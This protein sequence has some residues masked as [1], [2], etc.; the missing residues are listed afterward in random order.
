MQ[1]VRYPTM[2]SKPWLAILVLTVAACSAPAAPS[3][4]PA[5]FEEF[6]VHA[7]DAFAAMFRAVGN[8]DAGSD[9]E[10]SKSLDEA[11]QRGDPRDEL[12]HGRNGADLRAR[13][14]EV[15]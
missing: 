3:L 5:T 2:R 6:A 13:Q 10:L 7:C 11:V 12:D 1:L 8:P 14:G 9:S 15:T 4:A